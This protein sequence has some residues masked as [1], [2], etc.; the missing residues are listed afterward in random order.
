MQSRNGISC[1]EKSGC[2]W[3]HHKENKTRDWQPQF[4]QNKELFLGCVSVLLGV[5]DSSESQLNIDASMEKHGFFFCHMTFV[6]VTGYSLNSWEC[7][8]HD[9][10][11]L[12]ECKLSGA[13][14]K[15]GYWDL[16]PPHLLA[17]FSQI[18]QPLEQ[19]HPQFVFQRWFCFLPSR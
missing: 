11:F 16:S 2:L 17:L 12:S 1:E 14:Y 13:L 8:P 19:W 18:S 15:V 10:S 4:L 7:Y 9:F 3:E 5:V 6:P